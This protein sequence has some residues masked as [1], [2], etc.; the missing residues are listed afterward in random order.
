MLGWFGSVLTGL[1]TWS[2]LCQLLAHLGMLSG[3]LKAWVT[4]SNARWGAEMERTLS[5][6]G[7]SPPSFL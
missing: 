6:W 1:F 5:V 2:C 4:F 7:P 3:V